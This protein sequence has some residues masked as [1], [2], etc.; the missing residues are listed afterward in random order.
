M[1][2]LNVLAD[3][4][5]S[6]CNAERRRKRQV[7]I[8]PSSKVIVR[9]WGLCN[10]K[11]TLENSK[12]LMT[13][14]PEKLLFNSMEGWI[15][16]VLS[17]PGLIWALEIRK[18]G[19]GICSHPVNLGKLCCWYL[20]FSDIWCLPLVVGLWTMKRLIA[21]TWVGSSWVISSNCTKY[22]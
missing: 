2:R 16:A 20:T 8:R 13:T 4:L 15:N 21:N 7:L 17:A 14:E 9:F 18:S 10:A 1:V 12:S 19:H 11:V 6:I 22:N 3:A 5:K